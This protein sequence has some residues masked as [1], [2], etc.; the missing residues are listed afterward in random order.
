MSRQVAAVVL[1]RRFGS[2]TR[3]AVAL[4]LADHAD[5]DKWTTVVGQRRIAAEAEVGERTVRRVLS[6]FES[7][8]LIVRRR[9]HR[10]DGTR[11]SDELI[12]VREKVQAL[13]ATLTARTTTG[14]SGRLGGDYRPH[15]PDLP[16]TQAG[17][18]GQSLAAQEPSE[19]PSEEPEELAA[20]RRDEVWDAL[21]DRFGAPSND[22]SR[23]AR[24]RVVKLLKQSRATAPEIHRRID[25]WPLHFPDATLTA[26]ALAKH[27]DTLGRP[28]ARASREDVAAVEDLQRRRRRRE[29]AEQLD[30]DQKRGLGS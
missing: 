6:E 24:N 25:V 29:F 4:V 10:E 5:G 18:T 7:E 11:T 15:R 30:A 28:P 9:R 19:E 20:P 1:E 13:P 3:K 27:W 21:A 23:G 12:L 14:Q 2:T 17:P 8:G 26:T 16:A 22:S